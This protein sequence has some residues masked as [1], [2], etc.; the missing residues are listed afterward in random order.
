MCMTKKKQISGPGQ[1]L[2][3]FPT[4]M[5][6]LVVLRVWS[7]KMTSSAVANELQLHEIE[8]NIFEADKSPLGSKKLFAHT[9]LARISIP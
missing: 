7:N 4:K 8:K 2:N 3:Q 6:S 1:K 9:R 5:T